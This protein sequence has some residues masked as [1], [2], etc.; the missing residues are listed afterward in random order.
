MGRHTYAFTR[1]VL[2]QHELTACII[3]YL[4]WRWTFVVTAL[5]V[6]T[7]TE[8]YR[9]ALCLMLRYLLFLQ[10]VFLSILCVFLLRET[11]EKTVL[12]KLAE[13]SKSNKKSGI[14]KFPWKLKLD[15]KSAQA[16]RVALMRPISLVLHDRAVL[17]LG[18]YQAAA[19]GVIV[20]VSH[21]LIY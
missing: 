3:E 9:V 13:K 21:D 11:H 20:S 19:Y 1:L 17:L 12:R 15:A 7:E 4:S 6:R 5:A 2:P 16:L 8:R 18:I 10:G 14:P